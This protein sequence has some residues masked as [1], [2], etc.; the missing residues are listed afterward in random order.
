MTTR[1]VLAY[2]G[3][4]RGSA[5]IG[6]LRAHQQADVVTLT[7]DVGQER[8][9]EE[10]RARALALGAVRAHVLDRREAFARAAIAALRAGAAGPLDAPTVQSLP[11]PV[12]ASALAEVAA[13]ERAGAVAHAAGAGADLLDRAIAGHG[14]WPIVRGAVEPGAADLETPAT[15]DGLALPMPAPRW[16]ASRQLL[17]R[18]VAD[19]PVAAES[20]VELAF[21]NGV[22][23]SISGVAFSPAELL[24]SLALLAGRQGVGRLAGGV[25]APAAVA[26]HTA[27]G[28]LPQPDGVVRLTLHAGRCAAAVPGQP[29]SQL[30][31]P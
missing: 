2:S 20:M 12:I 15:A 8:D 24:D 7:V 27:Y 21:V 16:S 22:P 29:S 31:N 19:A 5:A 4:V 30:V 25:D 28:V 9:L 11:L 10:I 26:L 17:C 18:P 6:W 1:I 14:A 13:I 3:G 23:V